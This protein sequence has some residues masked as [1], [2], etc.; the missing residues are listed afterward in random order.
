MIK[1]IK[2][3]LGIT[4][5]EEALQAQVKLNDLQASVM[6]EIKEE[7]KML[8]DVINVGVDVHYKHDSWAVVCIDGQPEY[9][10]FLRLPA[11]D[12]REIKYFLRQYKNNYMIIDDPLKCWRGL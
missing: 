2:D 6:K 4:K 1:F 12:I 7:N 5:L 3:K 8:M 10:K 9:I 11:K